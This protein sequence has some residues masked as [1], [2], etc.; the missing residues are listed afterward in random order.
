MMRWQYKVENSDG[1]TIEQMNILGQLG[2][3]LVDVVI[4]DHHYTRRLYFKRL[5]EDETDK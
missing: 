3:E 1:L 2:W 4:I 5:I